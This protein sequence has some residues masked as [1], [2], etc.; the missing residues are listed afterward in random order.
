M[1][2][3]IIIG[4]WGGVYRKKFIKI[5]RY[6]IYI[7]IGYLFLENKEEINLVDSKLQTLK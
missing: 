2:I 6:N 7:S 4:N 3:V 5:F 1:S